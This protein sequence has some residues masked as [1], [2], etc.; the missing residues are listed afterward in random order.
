M[1]RSGVHNPNGISIG[2]AVSAGLTIATDRQ[3]D[4]ATPS[5]TTGQIYIVVRCGLI[6]IVYLYLL[7]LYG[8]PME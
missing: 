2:S 6:C 7:V 1:R 3:T 8:R 5:V 4:H